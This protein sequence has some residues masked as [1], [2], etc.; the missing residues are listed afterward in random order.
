M[1][2]LI[3]PDLLYFF[4]WFSGNDVNVDQVISGVESPSASSRTP[5]VGRKP[6]TCEFE[7]KSLHHHRGNG[8]SCK[9]KSTSDENILYYKRKMATLSQQ[10]NKSVYMLRQSLVPAA[11]HR[12]GK[13][14]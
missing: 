10:Y 13:T 12:T 7:M 3:S 4:P 1:K 14:E 11:I 2:S 9:S 8:G 6:S 5:D